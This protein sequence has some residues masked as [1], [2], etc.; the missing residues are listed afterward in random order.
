MPVIQR[1]P[2]RGPKDLVSAAHSPYA[3]SGPFA[4]AFGP[5]LGMTS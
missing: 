5:T 3:E 2:L 1:A 4:R